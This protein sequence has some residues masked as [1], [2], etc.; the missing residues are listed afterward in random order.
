MKN[1]LIDVVKHEHQRYPTV[2]DY[3]TD[4]AGVEHFRISD[5]GNT[6]YEHLVAIHE[7][8]ERIICYHSDVTNEAIDKFD[9]DFEATRE[10]KK[11][12]LRTPLLL[13]SVSA[14]RMNE[15]TA[16]PGDDPAAP[17]YHAHQIATVVERLLAAELGVNWNEYEKRINEL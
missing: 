9:M 16:E 6:K 17:Y 4:E 14:E 11:V 8:V 13:G 1:I 12:V 10:A 5:L 3:Y 7:L 2:G 15:L